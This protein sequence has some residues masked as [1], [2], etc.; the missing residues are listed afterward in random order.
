LGGV[1]FDTLK[2]SQRLK[3]MGMSEKEAVAQAEA[4]AEALG[5]FAETLVTREHLSAELAASRENFSAGLTAMKDDL[6]TELAATREN[7]RTG[8]TATKDD[9]RTELS[10]IR[11]TQRLHS[12]MLGVLVVTQLV[13]LFSS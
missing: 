12:W 2:Y 8:L 5:D 4:L 11:S 13:P 3:T 7:F 9:L 10:D 1:A 6:R